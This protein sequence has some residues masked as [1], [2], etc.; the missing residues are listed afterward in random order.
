MCVLFEE[1]LSE[2]WIGGVTVQ[3]GGVGVRRGEEKEG[4]STFLLLL[5]GL[6]KATTT[7][8]L[9]KEGDSTLFL[10]GN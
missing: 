7:F 6:W 9:N 4:K 5:L 2:E 3:V 1:G 10:N 8:Y